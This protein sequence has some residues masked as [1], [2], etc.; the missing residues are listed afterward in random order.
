MNDKQ[1][2]DAFT[3]AGGWFIAKYYE[4]IADFCG[5]NKELVLLIFEDGTDKRI[6]GTSTRVSSVKRIIEGGRQ[7]DALVKIREF[8]ENCTNTSRK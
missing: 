5:E 1:F 7:V 3:S 8:K 4:M 2:I 6:T